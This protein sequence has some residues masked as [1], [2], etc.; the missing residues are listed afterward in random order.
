MNIVVLDG[1]TLNPG[2]LSWADFEKLGSVKVYDRTP[3]DLTIERCKD[4][5][6]VITNKTVISNNVILALPKLKYVGVLSTGFNVVDINTAA[7]KGIIVSNVPAYST[8]SVAQ[9]T[10]ALLLELVT[11]VGIHNKSV[12]EGEWENS[13]D[14]S[15]SKTSLIELSG[16]TFGIIG[17]GRIGRAVSKIA[18]ALG[19]NLLVT[20]RSELKDVPNYVKVVHFNEM[21]KNSDVISLHLPLNNENSEFINSATLSLMKPTAYLLNTSRGGLINEI[22]LANALNKNKIA[23]AGLDVLSTEP[24]MKNNPLLNAKNCVITPHIAWATKAA[25]IRLMKIAEENIR[26][27]IN[28]VPQNIVS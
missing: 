10:F 15:Y 2:D 1:F 3:A 27:F 25:R 16:L 4:A 12:H 6:I 5:E 26:A 28:C 20:K 14:F 11:N 21:F 13:S 19:M 22:D 17:F 24:P 18:N 7:K 9:I 23:G 8:N